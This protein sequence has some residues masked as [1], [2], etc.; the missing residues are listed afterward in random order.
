MPCTSNECSMPFLI[1]VKLTLQYFLRTVFRSR[2]CRSRRRS[3][4][5]TAAGRRA[6]T[7]W[8]FR[9]TTH[10]RRA[11]RWTHRLWHTHS[12]PVRRRL[13]AIARRTHNTAHGGVETTRRSANQRRGGTARSVQLCYSRP[14]LPS[15]ALTRSPLVSL[16]LSL[17]SSQV[18]DGQQC[19]RA[20]RH[21]D[22]CGCW[23][24]PARTAYGQCS[25]ETSRWAAAV[26]VASD[27][28]C[29]LVVAAGST[30][31]SCQ[32]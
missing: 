15:Q 10:A 5:E 13:S 3:A 7:M 23:D 4:E 20:S 30:N 9:P 27:R 31:Y 25:A 28:Y 21:G 8:W 26:S 1:R 6:M 16:S 14:T 32:R 11:T 2:S 17:A 24:I 29:P 18:A 19:V 12:R 22:V